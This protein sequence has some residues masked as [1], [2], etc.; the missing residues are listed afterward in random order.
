MNFVNCPDCRME[1][2]ASESFCSECGAK[3]EPEN[4]I[5]VTP[6]APMGRSEPMEPTPPEMPIEPVESTIPGLIKPTVPTAAATPGVPSE[7][8]ARIAPADLIVLPEPVEPPAPPVLPPLTP[9]ATLSPGCTFSERYNVIE[10]RG[11][12]RTGKVYKVFDKAMQRE[13][14]L[15]LLKPELAKDGNA[16]KR[17]YIALKRMR[18]IVQRNVV[19][20]FEFT[21]EQGAL[22]LTTE[23]VPGRD[24]KTYFREM[25]GLTTEKIIAVAR[26]ICSGL[27]EAHRAGIIHLDLKPGNILIDKEG[28]VKITDLGLALSFFPK[29]ITDAG[30]MYGTPEYMSPEQIQGEELDQQSDIYSLGIILY[31]MITGRVPFSGDTP[32]AIG[33][34]QQNERPKNPKELNPHVPPE[35][36][37]LIL[38]CLEKDRGKR[39][40]T[41]EE[42]LSD[43]EEAEEK[44]AKTARPA[45]EPAA[46]SAAPPA[47][48]KKTVRAPVK[49]SAEKMKKIIFNPKKLLFPAALAVAVII[50]GVIIRRPALKLSSGPGSLPS[51]PNRV[52]IV[53]VPFKDLDPA[54]EHEYLGEGI[55]ETL[56]EALAGVQGLRVPAVSSILSV[57]SR[58]WASREI[59][60]KL[61]ADYRLEADFR[62]EKNSLHIAA[63]LLNQ[64]DGSTIWLKEYNRAREALFAVQQEIAQEV[65]QT[66]K[67]PGGKKE[68]PPVKMATNN[69]DAFGLY[70][71]GKHLQKQGGKANIEKSTEY[72]KRAAEKDPAF[73]LA[74]MGLAEAY[75]EL[76]NNSIWPPEQSFPK[77]KAAVLNALLKNANLSEARACLALIKESYEWDRASAERE[78]KEAIRLNPGCAAAHHGYA[79]FLSRLGRHEE[80]LHEI[81]LAQTLDPLS[82]TINA[83]VGAVLYF[84]RQYELAFVELSKSLL[85]DPLNH[86]CYFYTGLV[87]IQIPQ[88][89]KALESFRR[90]GELGGNAMNI[91]LHTAYIYSLQGRRIDAGKILTMAIKAS[92]ET[93]ISPVVLAAVYNGIGERDQVFA[94]LD[95]ALAEHDPGLVFLKVHPLFDSVQGDR[96]FAAVLNKIGL[97]E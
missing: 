94:C 47:A 57:R 78:Y 84:A 32:S 43:L 31:E 28:T 54:R 77:A 10:F 93:Y 4:K 27:A 81:R 34:K 42:L 60:K 36:N 5:A 87:Q 56:S 8:T 64:M 65:V 71:Q 1:N 41:A 7:S 83:H 72:F 40:Q 80:A 39:Y 21:E 30:V 16:Q 62:I 18:R 88:L 17:F 48:V 14:A 3:L 82:P 66:L 89:E 92:K 68:L 55:A 97:A 73:A 79:L 25:R 58:G 69:L 61:D 26:Q 95:K 90:A 29:A 15:R 51:A 52:T 20:I 86:A 19:R 37:L 23:Y 45:V 53:V 33:E 22:I 96:R 67:I 50:L 46:P 44:E 59:G 75:M 35:L 9:V 6:A 12:G 38:K 70:W 91:S 85:V 11:E 74:D 49:P 13:L 24:L 76:G 2:P 63:K